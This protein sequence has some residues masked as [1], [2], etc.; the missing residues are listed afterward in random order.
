M[1]A[2]TSLRSSLP[3]FCAL[4]AQHHILDHRHHRHELEVL[5]HHA[6]AAGDGVARR[7]EDHRLAV[8]QDLTRGGVV[9]AVD[10]I[11]QR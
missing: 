4:V 11:H 7:V 1:R 3:S 6:D 10:D 2:A 8:D 5:V 9:E